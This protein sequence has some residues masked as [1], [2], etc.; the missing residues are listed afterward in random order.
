MT[1]LREV[2][3]TLDELRR[4]G[5]P[6]A[7]A[8]VVKVE[9]SAYRRPGARMV[10]TPTGRRVGSVSGGCLE[11][12]VARK[13]WALTENGPVLLRYD[14]TDDEDMLWGLALGCR[15]V[16]HVLVERIDA[17]DTDPALEAVRQCVRGRPARLAGCVLGTVFWSDAQDVAPV[18]A[19]VL[20]DAEGRALADT[21]GLCGTIP[22]LESDLRSRLSAGRTAVVRYAGAGES[23]AGVIE[24]LAEVIEA[25]ASLVILGAGWDAVPLVN[26]AKAVGWDVTVVGRGESAA[27]AARFP[28]ADA[29]VACPPDALACHPGVRVDEGTMAV[30]MTHN[31]GDDFGY[32]A[33][34][35]TAP[36][37]A[38][39][40]YVGLL[41]PAKR[42]EQLLADLRDRAGAALDEALLER[43]YGPVGL[44][45][46]AET[47]A[48]IA[49]AVVAEMLAVRAG[50]EGESLRTKRAPIHDPGITLSRPLPD[51][52]LIAPVA[53][54]AG[55]VHAG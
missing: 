32:L 11:G 3:C 25:P 9:G 2:L 26:A 37:M 1:E 20:L 44:D 5:E 38:R 13:A 43:V 54:A 40:R 12:D 45:V 29:V 8:T 30:L 36:G 23:S 49:A 28:F 6:A 55:L 42:K 24:V 48:Q 19:R 17:Q 47:A 52:A 27:R 41:G 31:Y 33:A 15:G 35:L 22:G 16:V 21:A 34:L 50:R 46:G 14:S 7:L 39:P 53:E 4:A 51:R 10:V 18:G